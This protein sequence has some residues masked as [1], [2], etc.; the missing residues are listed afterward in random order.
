MKTRNQISQMDPKRRMWWEKGKISH[1]SKV[2]K[3]QDNKNSISKYKCKQELQ[4][5]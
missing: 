1:I 2:L 4:L 5:N 3:N